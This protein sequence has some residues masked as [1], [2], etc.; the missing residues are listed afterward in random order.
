MIRITDAEDREG[1]AALL[2]SARVRDAATDRRVA[3][4]VA[5]VRSGGDAAP[6]SPLFFLPS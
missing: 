6:M 1:V 3:R 4:I 2:S 5:D